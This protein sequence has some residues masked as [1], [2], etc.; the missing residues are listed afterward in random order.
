MHTALPAA[1]AALTPCS[2]LLQPCTLLVSRV[3]SE[4]A[5]ACCPA[6]GLQEIF[7]TLGLSKAGAGVTLVAHAA[8]FS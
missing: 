6:P 7:S 4:A 2:V 1:Q 5:Q 3:G 8:P